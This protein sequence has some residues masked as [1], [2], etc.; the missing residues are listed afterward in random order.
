M[1]NTRYIDQ[2]RTLAHN[3]TMAQCTAQHRTMFE[4]AAHEGAL[5]CK[6]TPPPSMSSF[7]SS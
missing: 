5:K 2:C 4:S 7:P 1:N 6:R 3:K